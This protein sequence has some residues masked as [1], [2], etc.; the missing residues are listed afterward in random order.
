MLPAVLKVCFWKFKQIQRDFEEKLKCSHIYCN[1]NAGTGT[2]FI[3]VT[4]NLILSI[5][6][7]F[8]FI[9]FYHSV[10]L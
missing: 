1:S 8:F 6:A 10:Q 4:H 7:P 5:I 9:F 3:K 2:K